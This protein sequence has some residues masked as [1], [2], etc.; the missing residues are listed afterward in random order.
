MNS[1]FITSVVKTLT[2]LGA[3]D[4]DALANPDMLIILLIVELLLLSIF[5][6]NGTPIRISS[7]LQDVVHQ[8]TSHAEL[9][10]S[11]SGARDIVFVRQWLDEVSIPYSQPVLHSN[12]SG[13]I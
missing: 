8:A 11:N 12:N 7:G 1:S 13:A 2:S 9:D 4:P 3:R 6:F 5:Y 10:A